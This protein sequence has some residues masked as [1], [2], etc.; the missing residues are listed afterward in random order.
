MLILFLLIISCKLME[1]IKRGPLSWQ[2]LLCF[3]F[4]SVNLSRNPL[5]GWRGT[6]DLSFNFNSFHVW[7]AKRACFFEVVEAIL[8]NSMCKS[9]R[10]PRSGADG[11]G[12]KTYLL[13]LIISDTFKLM[14]TIKR[15]RGCQHLCF[16]S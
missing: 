5:Y 12:Q 6:G 13:I 9:I 15:A 2:N 7:R 4:N 16:N 11:K 1:K 3:N 8:G 14:E 10:I